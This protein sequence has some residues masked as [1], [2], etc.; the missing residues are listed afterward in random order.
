MTGGIYLAYST[1]NG[2]LPALPAG[3]TGDIYL[4]NSTFNG[5]LPALPAGLIGDISLNN[6]TFNGT[7]PALPA[8][9]TGSIYLQSSTFSGYTAGALA[10]QKSLA[11]VYLQATTAAIVNS[12]LA[13]SVTSLS[14]SGRVH[15]AL[16]I[17]GSSPAPTGQG[18]T[19][20]ATLIAA[21]W[22]VTT[23]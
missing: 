9:L 14:I 3:M 13:D 19:D 6:S 16:S 7:L 12:I 8:G 22:T 10:T 15:E 21:G 5:T 20:K 18:L 4:N 23:H 1:F 2:T 17:V 11:Y